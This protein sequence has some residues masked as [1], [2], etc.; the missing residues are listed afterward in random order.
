MSITIRDVAKEAGVSV[1]TVSKVLNGW[2]TISAATIDRVQKTA[3]SLH[4][5]PNARAVNFAKKASDNIIF[6]T[7]LSKEEAY[8]N[9][10]MFDIMCGVH[11]ALS[12]FSHSVTLVDT[13]T[14]GIL[15]ETVSRIISKGSADGM[16]IH[17]SALNEQIAEEISIAHFPHIVIGNPDFSNQLCWIDTNHTLAGEFAAAHL[18]QRGYTK[19]A[20][21]GGRK[22][23]FISQQ[24]LKGVR[25]TLLKA[26]HRMNAEHLIY[27][28]SS[29]E[30]AYKAAEN[31]FAMEETP[32]AIICENNLIAL[33]VARA[34]EHHAIRIPDDIAFLTFDRYPYAS[35][36]DPSPSI[37]DIDVYDMGMQAGEMMIR[38]L[39]NPSLLV[40][41]YTTLPI[42][43]Q[44]KTT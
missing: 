30:A 39:E 23:D 31:L 21:I 34:M 24:R 42:V 16:I 35:I 29:R 3:K 12:K 8:K 27:T 18:L 10:H 40:Q 43:I 25:S 28:D 32:D 11:S 9:P 41:S 19:I 22:T 1:S 14:E 37:V 38:K 20:F 6:L 17:G 5:T 7:S 44:G 13:S 15:G 36:I 2:T 26:R 4:Y 33:G